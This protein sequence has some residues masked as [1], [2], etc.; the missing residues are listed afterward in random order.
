MYK[1]KVPIS[2][3]ISNPYENTLLAFPDLLSSNIASRKIKDQTASK[4]P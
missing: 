3:I 1:I 2:I 4:K